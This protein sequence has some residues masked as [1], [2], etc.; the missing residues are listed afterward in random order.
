MATL[1]LAGFIAGDG[2]VSLMWE[3]GAYI[4]ITAAELCISVIGLQLAFEEAPNHMKSVITGVF[5]VTVFVG[6]ILSGMFARIY[7]QMSPGE[8]FAIMS[9]MIAVVTVAFYFVG[10]RFDRNQ[11]RQKDRLNE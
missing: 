8:Y 7:T 11:D 5:L 9:G 3:L 4:L 2:R 10:R 1:S 6:N